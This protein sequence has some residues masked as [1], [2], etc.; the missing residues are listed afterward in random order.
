MNS[1]DIILDN[2]KKANLSQI[3]MPSNKIAHTIFEDKNKQFETT[4]QS[5]G[6]LASWLSNDESIE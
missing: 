1:R 5:V 2:I 3:P 4:L 6:G